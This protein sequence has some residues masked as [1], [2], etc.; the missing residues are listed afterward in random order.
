MKLYYNN[1]TDGKVMMMIS[2]M[3]ITTFMWGMT[4]LIEFIAWFGLGEFG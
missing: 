1:D 3:M 2:V 4:V